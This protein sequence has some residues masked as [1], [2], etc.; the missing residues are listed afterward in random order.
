MFK[1]F[2]YDNFDFQIDEN[3]LLKF[4]N[5]DFPSVKGFNTI[6]VN[7]K[8]HSFKTHMLI[9]AAFGVEF[10]S[11]FLGIDDKVSF[12]V[13]DFGDYLITEDKIVYNLLKKEVV[14]NDGTIFFTDKK[15]EFSFGVEESFQKVFTVDVLKELTDKKFKESLTLVVEAP[16][17]IFKSSL[18]NEFYSLDPFVKLTLNKNQMVTVHRDGLTH[19]VK[20]N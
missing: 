18:D 3:G 17:K 9:I 4:N 20:I 7:S 1:D 10:L 14:L 13:P 5:K 8:K 12:L 2:K 15:K 11:K 16:V 19:F 6:E